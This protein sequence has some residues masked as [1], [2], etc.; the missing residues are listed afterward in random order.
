M[1]GRHEDGDS[2][3]HAL[4]QSF[5]LGALLLAVGNDLRSSMH[6][7]YQLVF[8]LQRWELAR[9]NPE[10]NRLV[11]RQPAEGLEGARALRI[12]L[13]LR[14]T[15]RLAVVGGSRQQTHVVGICS[16]VLEERNSNLVIAA[17][18]EVTSSLWTP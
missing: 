2:E 17:L 10:Y 4:V 16:D 18:A 3:E 11:R 13:Q 8:V 1:S 9:H 5:L 6:L 15:E 14:D 7:L 12:V